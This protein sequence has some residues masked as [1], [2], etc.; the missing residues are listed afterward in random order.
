MLLGPGLLTAAL[1][2][3]VCCLPAVRPAEAAPAEVK[4]KDYTVLVFKNAKN[5]L[6]PFGLLDM[7]EMELAGSSEQVNVLVEFGRL[8]GGD[9]S[10]VRRY[11]VGKDTDASSIGSRVVWE[12]PHA[13][14]GDWRE[15]ADFVSWGKKNYPA[16]KYL[17][18]IW[19]HGNGWKR[20]GA[21]RAGRGIS[22][23]DET[24]SHISTP[25]LA[26]VFAAAGPVDVLAFDA[27]LMQTVEVAYEVRRYAGLVVGSEETEPGEGY[28]YD[29]ILNAL[30]AR[31]GMSPEE[32]ARAIVESYRDRNETLYLDTTQSALRT[33]ALDGLRER[34]DAWVLAAAS[35][36]DSVAVKRALFFAHGFYEI[37]QKDLSDILRL[38]A[39]GASC[40][41]LKTASLEAGR[42]LEEKVVAANGV[43][44]YSHRPARG[45][46]VYASPKYS[47]NE[48]YSELAWSQ[49]GL[50]D[51]FLSG[52][53]SVTEGK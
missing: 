11:Y 52:G 53:I 43:S 46:A 40:A 2:A 38:T 47:Y 10:G 9:W 23:D 5:D 20:R 51:D 50:W 34:L 36:G 48:D 37:D 31:P 45:L 32:L 4:V 49:D 27:C 1:A 8:P 17:L 14:M 44:G 26:R 22:F 12:R 28:P 13:D 29:L 16:K 19:N 30:N 24:G 42:W 21:L 39:E 3:A 6:E 41:A 33:A 18:V 7:N 15:L 25:E 35:S